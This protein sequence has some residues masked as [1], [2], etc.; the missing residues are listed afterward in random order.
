MF[1]A[2]IAYLQLLLHVTRGRF[3]SAR[4]DRGA[5]TL[6]LAIISAIL[7]AAAFGI[8]MVIMNKVTQKQGVISNY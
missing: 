2:E 8:A 1:S 6:E 5:S 7:V 3:E 4:D